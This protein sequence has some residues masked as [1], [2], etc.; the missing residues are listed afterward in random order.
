MRWEQ[1]KRHTHTIT[2]R[3]VVLVDERDEY[4]LQPSGYSIVY[5]EWEQFNICCQSLYSFSIVYL[6]CIIYERKANEK[7]RWKHENNNEWLFVR[8]SVEGIT[9]MGLSYIQRMFRRCSDWCGACMSCQ[10]PNQK[11][12][13]LRGS[14][15]FSN[16]MK[17]NKIKVTWHIFP[18]CVRNPTRQTYGCARRGEMRYVPTTHDENEELG[19]NYYYNMFESELNRSCCWV[20]RRHV[21]VVLRRAVDWLPFGISYFSSYQKWFGFIRYKTL[22]RFSCSEWTDFHS[23]IFTR[24]VS[25]M[26]ANLEERNKSRQNSTDDVSLLIRLIIFTKETHRIFGWCCG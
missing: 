15:Q 4:A 3:S 19:I 16:K 2:M 13:G 14:L 5:E 26:P 1:K 17:K 25:W 18:V 9:C 7:E 8:S 12:D 23:G 6:G 10:I 22:I 11:S 20:E 24:R 21:C